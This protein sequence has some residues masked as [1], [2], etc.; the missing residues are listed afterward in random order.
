MDTKVIFPTQTVHL[1]KPKQLSPL[2]HES[3]REVIESLTSENAKLKE[4][5][6]TLQKE[7]E[8]LG[9]SRTPLSKVIQFRKEIKNLK[10][11]NKVLNKRIQQKKNTIL[12]SIPLRNKRQMEKI[13]KFTDEKRLL[14]ESNQDLR[15]RLSRK[16]T[17][18]CT[19][20]QDLETSSAK[21]N[22]VCE[23]RD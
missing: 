2:E 20:S 18:I 15:E 22:A 21:M 4:G 10:K 16:D 8:K 19:L 1:Q 3:C 12:R 6:D 11:L 5:I 9:L 17:E 7:K 23:E 14:E 13:T